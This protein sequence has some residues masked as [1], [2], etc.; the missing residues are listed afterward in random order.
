MTGFP[1]TSGAVDL[2]TA[3]LSALLHPLATETL[4]V[5][6]QGRGWFT[7]WIDN[8]Q[9][10]SASLQFAGAEE[11]FTAQGSISVEAGRMVPVEISV[12]FNRRDRLS[13]WISSRVS[14]VL[15]ATNATQAT[16]FLHS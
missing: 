2:V 13:Y 9:V 16:A 12:D 1:P 10:L 8:K 3:E 14:A 15:G 4:E 5:R 7:L 11:T 6:V